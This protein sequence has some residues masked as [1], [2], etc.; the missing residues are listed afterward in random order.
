MLIRAELEFSQHVVNSLLSHSVQHRV[1]FVVSLLDSSVCVM[2]APPAYEKA[3]SF[4]GFVVYA[5][6]LARR[7]ELHRLNE[8]SHRLWDLTAL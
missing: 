7:T 4:L 6:Y 8:L 5:A 1:C 3:S 2:A